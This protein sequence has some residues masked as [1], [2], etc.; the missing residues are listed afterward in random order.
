MKTKYPE[1]PWMDPNFTENQRKFPWEELQ[2]YAGLH[3]AWSWEGTTIVA[4]G[5]T[6]EEAWDNVK[7]AGI[8]PARVVFDFV[9]V[10]E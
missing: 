6:I 4:S 3:V 2:K 7:Q 8:D 9:E 10:P 1:V 5:S